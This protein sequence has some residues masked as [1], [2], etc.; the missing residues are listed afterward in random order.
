MPLT[1]LQVADSVA[2]LAAAP[3]AN[4]HM[5]RDG[6]IWTLRPFNT[7]WV[8]ADTLAAICVRSTVDMTKMWVREEVD[9]WLSPEMFGA[10]GDGLTDDSDAFI[11]CSKVI[12]AL[13]GGSVRLAQNAVY[14]VGKQTAGAGVYYQRGE[15]IL[16][17][18]NVDH[19]HVD[20]NGA[21]MKL[22][23]GMKFG[24][25]DPVTGEK[26][27]DTPLNVD[28]SKVA[29]VGVMIRAEGVREVRIIGG[30]CDGNGATMT[31]GG[32]AYDNG[33]QIVN[34]GVYVFKCDNVVVESMYLH[35]FGTDGIAIGHPGLA[36]DAPL[37]PVSLRNVRSIYSGRNGLSL[38]ASNAF[39]AENCVFEEAGNCPNPGAPDG[40]IASSPAACVDVE[41]EFGGVNHN[42]LFD[43]CR[44]VQGAYGNTAFVADTGDSRN[45]CVRNSLLDGQIWTSKPQTLFENCEIRGVFAK[46]LGNSGTDNSVIR[47]C[48]GIDVASKATLS[49]GVPFLQGTGAGAGVVVENLTVKL[50]RRHIDVRGMTVRGAT[51]KVA[52]GSDKLT[53][54][55]FAM[56]ADNADLRDVTLVDLTPVGASNSYPAGEGLYVTMSGAKA[57]RCEI[58]PGE[59]YTLKWNSWSVGAGGY[60]HT[61]RRDGRYDAGAV[62]VQRL[63]LQRDATLGGGYY[64]WASIE[65]RTA[66]PTSGSYKRGSIIFNANAASG[67]PMG[68]MCTVASTATT[69]ATWTALP[70]IA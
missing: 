70:N 40:R 26:L 63:D 19:F 6:S 33:W 65:S 42:V 7:V 47:N 3:L 25:F 50:V 24:S 22:K 51:I 48:H 23:P 58:V 44:F 68:W 18:Y 21:T 45:I 13:G 49:S 55:S 20:L 14:M 59:N 5:V 36:A 29:H 9:G 69:A 32:K 53:S 11:A 2:E 1:D 46:L 64:E 37:K 15:D 61:D 12:A 34:Y 39:V 28:S 62:A 10:K 66:A 30:E 31:V 17:A 38:T 27:P 56:L 43:A 52:T 57:Q 60:P 67:Q 16:Y 54:K 35:D 4:A 8:T 41:A